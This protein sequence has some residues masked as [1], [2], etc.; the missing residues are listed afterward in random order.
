MSNAVVRRRCSAVEAGAVA[1][2]RK[3][4]P[5]LSFGNHGGGCCGM[6]HLLGFDETTKAHWSYCSDSYGKTPEERIEN[7]KEDLKLEL[8][9]LVLTKSKRPSGCVEVVLTDSQVIQDNF[10]HHKNLLAAGFTRVTRFY[11]SNS[12][13]YC[14]IYHQP[15]GQP[16]KVSRRDPLAY[17]KPE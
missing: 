4:L 16:D 11:N 2:K 10:E 12:G 6:S 5:R 1:P 15:Y 3:R 9:D 8:L 14:N 17:F 13:N 7:Y